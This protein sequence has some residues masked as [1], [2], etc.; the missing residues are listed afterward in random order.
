[1]S[2]TE[3][4]RTNLKEVIDISISAVK[5][6]YLQNLL[7]KIVRPLSVI[8]LARLLSPSTYG[9][10]AVA[11]T[12]LTFL[13][14]FRDFGLSKALIQDNEHEETKMFTIV[15]WF[16]LVLSILLS[17]LLVLFAPSVAEFFHSPESTPVIQVL[18]LSLVFSAL[19]SVHRAILIRKMLFNKLFSVNVLPSLAPFFITIPLAYAGFG[20]WSLVSGM[21]A[22]SIMTV[23]FLWYHVPW[24][25]T[26][27]I[28]F[29][30]APSILKFGFWVVLEA[31]MGWFY[32]SG[33]NVIVGHYL[34]TRDFGMYTV[35]YNMVVLLLS[36]VL[37]P[38]TSIAYPAL[39]KLQHE[40]NLLGIQLCKLMRLSALASLPIGFGIFVVAGSAG[41]IIFGQKWTGI[42]TPLA[43]LAATQGLSWVVASNSEAFRAMGRPDIV[44]KFQIYKLFYTVPAY[45]IGA[46]YSL[47]V[48]CFVKLGVVIVG[49]FIW[50]F[51]TAKVFLFSFQTLYEYLHIPFLATAG[52][53]IVVLAGQ[54]VFS[55]YVEPLAPL[56]DLLVF[57]VLG[58]ATYIGIIFVFDVVLLKN[59]F[60][61]GMRAAGFAKK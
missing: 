29:T 47:E 4:Q 30:I 2:D 9:I 37:T 5:W 21:L 42:E 32:I 8:I 34:S 58:A 1:M 15:F 59:V 7:P 56:V 11:T 35:S 23:F 18:S 45:I 44:P 40:K 50:L 27:K 13:E 48:F 60:Q 31:L 26:F 55:Q 54:A 10:L 52:M 25:P 14:I 3:E 51:V 38:M 33:D 43:L 22:S 6:T 19:A 61:L 24:R 20:V 41:A 53:V 28:D 17:G 39:S 49:L 36:I 12:T 46:Q 57:S 16:N